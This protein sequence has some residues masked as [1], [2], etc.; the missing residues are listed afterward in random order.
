MSRFLHVAVREGQH[1]LTVIVMCT[2]MPVIL[3]NWSGP[4]C[5][6]NETSWLGVRCSFGE[7]ASLNLSYVVQGGFLPPELYLLQSLQSFACENCSLSGKSLRQSR[8]WFCL[9]DLV[10]R[11]CML[12][13][14]PKAKAH[15][16]VSPCAMCL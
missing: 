5:N 14:L 15:D 3:Q 16:P 9:R 8:N 4:V 6:G 12:R 11:C 10:R 13:P 7:V 1:Y 2:Q